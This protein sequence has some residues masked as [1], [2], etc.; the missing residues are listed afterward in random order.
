MQIVSRHFCPIHRVSS[1]LPRFNL[2]LGNSSKGLARSGNRHRV[3]AALSPRFPTDGR[4]PGRRSCSSGAMRQ[5]MP[6]SAATTGS[7]CDG[8]AVTDSGRAHTH[9]NAGAARLWRR[10]RAG[11][12]A[13]WW[14]PLECALQMCICWSIENGG[15]RS[16]R[17]GMRT[18]G[19]HGLLT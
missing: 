3:R 2:S 19:P 8:R 12:K 13:L 11:R 18:T 15:A 14:A 9:P 1:S 17:V 4:A 10:H 6:G 7:C 16:K 5:R